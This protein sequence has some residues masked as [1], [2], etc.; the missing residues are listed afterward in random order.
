[1]MAYAERS[2]SQ[3]G[4]MAKILRESAM[5]EAHLPAISECPIGARPEA[6]D[7]GQARVHH[8]LAGIHADAGALQPGTVVP[9][10]PLGGI[11]CNSTTWR[12]SWVR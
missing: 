6:M 4:G 9:G 8:T 7:S 10:H 3:A 11:P 2:L 5:L 1:M 12:W